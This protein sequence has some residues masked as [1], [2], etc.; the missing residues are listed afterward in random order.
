MMF[1]SFTFVLLIACAIFYYR[2]GE[3]EGNSG[4]VW[5]G[6]SIMTS[7]LTWLVFRWGFLGTLLGQVALFIGI[8]LVR[9]LRKS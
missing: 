7:I 8:T 1:Y 9:T 6:V 4:A 2:A 3:F 5:A